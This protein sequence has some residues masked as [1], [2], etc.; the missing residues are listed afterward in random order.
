MSLP[1]AIILGIIIIPIYAY[2]WASIYRWEN[3]RRV[4][5]N[6]FKPMTKKQFNSI[7]IVHAICAAIFVIIAIFLSY[8]K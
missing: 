8:F 3:N 5:R 6:N 2:F 4:R 1:V 7:L